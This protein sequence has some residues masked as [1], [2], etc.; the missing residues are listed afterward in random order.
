MEVVEVHHLDGFLIAL[1]RS[2]DVSPSGF[3][4]AVVCWHQCSFC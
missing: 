1:Q 2:E 3:V 4:E